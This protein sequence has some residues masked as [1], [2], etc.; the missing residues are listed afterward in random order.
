MNTRNIPALVMLTAGLVAGIVMFRMHYSL[1]TMSW[2]I[3]LVFAV[4]YVLGCLIRLM[5]DKF[6]M[7]QEKKKEAEQEGEA[8]DRAAGRKAANRGWSCDRETVA[9][10]GNLWR[11]RQENVSGWI[12]REQKIRASGRRSSWNMR[13]L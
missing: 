1:Y 10:E 12:M 4:F 7:Q 5:L 3:L 9:K 13:R 6:G 2:V 8:G 11:K